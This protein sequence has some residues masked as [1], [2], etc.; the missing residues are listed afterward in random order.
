MNKPAGR[1]LARCHRIAPTMC[2]WTSGGS[3]GGG[4]TLFPQLGKPKSIKQWR[5]LMPQICDVCCRYKYGDFLVDQVYNKIAKQM[6]TWRGLIHSASLHVSVCSACTR[7]AANWCQLD[8][9][10]SMKNDKEWFIWY[11]HQT[12]MSWVGKS[13]LYADFVVYTWYLSW[14]LMIFNESNGLMIKLWRVAGCW[15]VGCG[16]ARFGSGRIFTR[17]GMHQGLLKLWSW[18]WTLLQLTVLY[19]HYTVIWYDLN[20]FETCWNYKLI[21]NNRQLM[22]SKKWS[23]LSPH[24]G[25]TWD[26]WDSAQMKQR[27]VPALGNRDV[28]SGCPELPEQNCLSN[29]HQWVYR[30][31]F[32]FFLFLRRFEPCLCHPISSHHIFSIC[33][34][35]NICFIYINLHE[36]AFCDVA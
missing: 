33:F 26:L 1:T 22:I 30:C 36:W 7:G 17:W 12:W 2:T 18:S 15:Q 16:N 4:G 19:I 20:I 11:S 34:S 23:K 25:R 13:W 9:I 5:I 28:P 35:S 21:R 27:M 14:Y 3:V 31:F 29:T 24:F 10:G 32:L 6:S 8:P